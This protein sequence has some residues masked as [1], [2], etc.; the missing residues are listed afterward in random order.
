MLEDCYVACKN[1]R[2]Q[3]IYNSNSGKCDLFSG[4]KNIFS[5]L[6]SVKG[7]YLESEFEEYLKDDSVKS[8]NKD[9]VFDAYRGSS[10]TILCDKYYCSN[11]KVN[12]NIKAVLLDFKAQWYRKNIEDDGDIRYYN[13][14]VKIVKVLNKAGIFTRNDILDYIKEHNDLHNIDG[15]SSKSVETILNIMDI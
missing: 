6:R 11:M 12:D 3:C 2:Q 14:P 10:M 8:L 7:S 4:S 1:C 15:C 5:R 13:L 9:I